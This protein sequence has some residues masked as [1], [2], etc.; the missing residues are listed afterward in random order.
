[1][2]ETPSLS[3]R[4]FLL[5]ATVL[6]LGCI[7]WLCFGWIGAMG[8]ISSCD[9]DLL[10]GIFQCALG[11][12]VMLPIPFLVARIFRWLYSAHEISP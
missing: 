1:M 9:G 7:T 8:I 3:F 2:P 10:R 5:A 12:G 11:L 6:W 4:R